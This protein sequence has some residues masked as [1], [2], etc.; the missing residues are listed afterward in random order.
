MSKFDDFYNYAN[1]K[2]WDT[3]G[4]QQNINNVQWDYPL[5]GQCV[6]L[7][8]TYLNYLG[9]GLKAYGNAIDFWTNRNTNGILNVCDVVSSPQ[10]GDIVV[11]AG[12]DPKYG[13]I[14]IYKDGQAFT[15]NCC[16]NPRATIYPLSYQGQIYGYLRP[17]LSESQYNQSQLINEHAYATLKFDIQKRRD[18]PDGLVVETLKAGRKLEYTQKWIGNGHRYISWVEH[19]PDG[20]SYRYFVAVNG[21]EKGTEPWATFSELGEKPSPQPPKKEFPDSV[22]FKGIDISEHNKDI[23]IKGNDFVIIR[24]TYGTYTDKYFLQNVQ[25]CND[26]KIPF[27][28]YCYDYALNDEQALEQP[29]YLLK[30]LQDNKIVPQLGVWFD[31]EDADGYKKKNGVLNKE[32]CSSSCKIFCDYFSEKGYF[33]GVYSTKW[34][35]ENLCPT[36]YSKWVANWGT[37]DGTCQADF[38]N[39]A[40]IHQYTS[41]PLDKNVMYVDMGTMASCPKEEIV[42]PKPEQP[43]FPDIDTDQMNKFFSVWTEIGEKILG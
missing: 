5:G 29:T 4:N 32:R 22:K 43:S 9:Y 11:S 6:S 3:Y 41:I 34:W 14:F 26:L 33:T 23:D 17:K 37:N 24:A 39:Y 35:F 40:I 20:N 19:Q 30:L 42:T 21:N 25:K 18:T 2:V 31:M 10:N 36:N 7:I 27:G 16:N 13:H 28:V 8:K 15:Q 1:G 12:G 38:S